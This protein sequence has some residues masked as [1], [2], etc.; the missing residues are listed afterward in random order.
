MFSGPWEKMTEAGKW[1]NILM[2]QARIFGA[3]LRSDPG[4]VYDAFLILQFYFDK[5]K[6]VFL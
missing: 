1:L 4:V 2:G 6:R 3:E 5:N